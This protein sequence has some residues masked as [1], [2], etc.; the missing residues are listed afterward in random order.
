MGTICAPLITNLFP[1][2]YERDIMSNLQKSKRF[3][4]IDKFNDTSR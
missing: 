3:N 4:L 2:C 1:Y